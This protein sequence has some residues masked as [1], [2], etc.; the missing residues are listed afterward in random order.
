VEVVERVV[1]VPVARDLAPRRDEWPTLLRKL[2]AQ[3]DAGRIYARDLPDL[4][5]AL[6]DLTAAYNRRR[7]ARRLRP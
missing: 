1:Q 5:T 3:L 7:G 6:N 2:T 4:G